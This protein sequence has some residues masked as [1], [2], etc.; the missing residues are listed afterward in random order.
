LEKSF[1][2][3][4]ARSSLGVMATSIWRSRSQGLQQY[5]MIASEVLIFASYV[6]GS[7][8][9]AEIEMAE[10]QQIIDGLRFVDAAP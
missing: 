4:I 2:R 7:L 10:A 6:M 1:I 3:R 5:W 9:T 8:D